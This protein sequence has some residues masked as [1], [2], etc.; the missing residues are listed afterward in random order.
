MLKQC[1]TTEEMITL[2]SRH[3]VSPRL[4]RFTATSGQKAWA[5]S[6]TITASRAM[7]TRW[8]EDL[9]LENLVQKYDSRQSRL[10]EIRKRTD[11]VI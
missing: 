2:L 3:G 9:G 6:G 10:A 1:Q 5:L 7:P 11:P 8:F 4:A